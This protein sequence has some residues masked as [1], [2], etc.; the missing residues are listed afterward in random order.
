MAVEYTI[1]FNF[2]CV[3]CPNYEAAAP[4]KMGF[5]T[6]HQKKVSKRHSCREN[7]NLAAGFLALAGGSR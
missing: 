4:R 2:E 7:P 6:V 1:K 3:N 5:C